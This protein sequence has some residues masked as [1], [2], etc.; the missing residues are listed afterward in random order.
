MEISEKVL[1]VDDE[2][3]NLDVLARKLAFTGYEILSATSGEEAIDKAM[4][5]A[6]QIILLDIMM[7]V[8]D[9]YETCQKLK[10]LNQTKEI[11]IIFM[12]AL[13]DTDD[14][15]RAFEVGG[16]DY[17]TKPF[18]SGE[19]L[20]RVTTHI[21][22]RRLQ[23]QLQTQNKQLR[24]EIEAHRRSQATVEYLRDE[25]KAVH[26]YDEIIG[27]SKPLSQLLEKA[28]V[29]A[30]TDTTV[31]IQGET[32][33][34]KEL[35]VR[36]IHNR[37]QRCDYPLVKVNCAALP[38]DLIE[39]EIFGHEKGAFTGA[40]K[41][42]KGKFEL[43]D[44]G[45]IFLDEVG[46]LSL[47]AQAK[48]LRILQEQEF[49]RVG[50]EQSIRVDAR[51][52]AAT[53][54]S[55]ES[56]VEKGHF[57]ADLFY[58]LNVF[59]LSVPPLRDRKSD[60]PLLA[61][62]FVKKVARKLGRTVDGISQNSVAKLVDYSWPGNIR[63]LENIIERSTILSS[64]TIIDVDESLIENQATKKKQNPL[65]TLEEV[66]RTHILQILTQ[67]NWVIEG[68]DKAADI[69]G[70]NSSTLRGRMRK[71]GINKELLGDE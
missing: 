47:E 4:S 59:P 48:L 19:V 61:E 71:L 5:E 67:T 26:N 38:K 25:I 65:E 31:L 30:G 41:Q 2:P 21:A 8:M 15:I 44:K 7:P 32:G 66:E 40:T 55:L 14:K 45:T 53:N 1:I 29:V 60:I 35:V 11:P 20:A 52:I 17:I 51:V 23:Q 36:A 10:S 58:R 57:R 63:E 18:H 46:E 37:S 13:T 22:N 42:R 69:L 68:Q 24:K 33:T 50:G 70:L 3:L 6:P 27:I 12:T 39:S 43:A 34:G 54:R 49:E 9:G 62:F 28:S 16:T 56:D 64:G